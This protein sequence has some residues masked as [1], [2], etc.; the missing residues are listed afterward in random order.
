MTVSRFDWER[1]IDEA[2]MSLG[3]RAVLCTLAHFM[4]N[5]TGVARPS[6]ERLAAILG[7]DER[8]VRRHLS[9]ARRAGFLDREGSSY[10][11]RV[12]PYRATIPPPKAGSPAR[13]SVAKADAVVRLSSSKGGQ[14]RPQRRAVLSEEAGTAA[15]P[16]LQEHSSDHSGVRASA[17]PPQHIDL[18]KPHSHWDCINAVC[19]QHKK[20][21]ER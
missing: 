5:D 14:Q 16:S 15:R 9:A 21:G 8:T 2:P 6:I 13:L 7:T 3:Q 10:V 1:A 12:A 17:D 20:A 18:L 19:F 4:D 11:G